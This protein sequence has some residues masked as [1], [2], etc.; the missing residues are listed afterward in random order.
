MKWDD[1]YT[2]NFGSLKAGRE[3]EEKKKYKKMKKKQKENTR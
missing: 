1:I 2:K 3:E